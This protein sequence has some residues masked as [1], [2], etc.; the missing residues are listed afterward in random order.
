MPTLPDLLDFIEEATNGRLVASAELYA[1]AAEAEEEAM[2]LEQVYDVVLNFMQLYKAYNTLLSDNEHEQDRKG[3]QEKEKRKDAETLRDLV[4]QSHRF[5][6]QEASLGG[7]QQALKHLDAVANH[8][9]KTKIS[10]QIKE[11][12]TKLK[13]LQ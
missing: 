2:E 7:L 3:E 11:H 9:E 6:V 12:T 10:L 1:K 8:V 13:Q 4:G 5:I